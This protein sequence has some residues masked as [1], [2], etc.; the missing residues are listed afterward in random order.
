MQQK[1]IEKTCT[2][3]VLSKQLLGSE[4]RESAREAR[5]SRSLLAAWFFSGSTGAT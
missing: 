2:A 5:D 1:C 3:C 4:Y